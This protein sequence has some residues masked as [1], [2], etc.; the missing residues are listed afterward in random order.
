[1][2]TDGNDFLPHFYT[3]KILNRHSMFNVRRKTTTKERLAQR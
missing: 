2:T 1:M 3:Q